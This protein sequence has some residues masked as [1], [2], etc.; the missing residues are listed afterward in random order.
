MDDFIL[1]LQDKKQCIQIKQKIE[2]FLKKELHLE[3]NSKSRYFPYNMG[4]D[5]CGYRTFT[6]HRLLRN[7]SKKKIK[8]K[9]KHWN[10]LYKSKKL[11]LKKAINS[12]NSWIGHSSH[13]NSY[14]LQQKI[15][16]NCDFIYNPMTDINDTNNQI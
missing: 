14:K 10:K 13:C 1:L 5:F 11:N 16:K 6:T 15:Y 12:L 2:I 4:I 9:V 3:L 8:R 7:N